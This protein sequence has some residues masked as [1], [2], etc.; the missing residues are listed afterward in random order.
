[1]EKKVGG[2]IG[3]L[4]VFPETH[5]SVVR[6]KA[7]ASRPG[8]STGV[9]DSTLF[10]GASTVDVPSKSRFSYGQHRLLVIEPDFTQHKRKLA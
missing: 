1:M 10:M 7:P 8:L 2:S 5:P 9:G 6:R 4:L 3:F